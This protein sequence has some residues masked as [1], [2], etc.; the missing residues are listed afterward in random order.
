MTDK[1]KN[2]NKLI[3]IADSSDHKQEHDTLL[4][5][6]LVLVTHER[7]HWGTVC[8]LPFKGRNIPF[9]ASELSPQKV[10]SQEPA[11][12]VDHSVIPG[13]TVL[14]SLGSSLPQAQLQSEGT[15]TAKSELDLED[16]Y[17]I[18]SFDNDMILTN[19]YYGYEQGQKDNIVKGRL[20]N[21]I[22]FW[23]TVLKASSFVI[24]P[25]DKGYK[26][27]FF[28]KLLVSFSPNNRSALAD[29]DFVNEAVSSLLCRGLIQ[30]VRK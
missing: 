21:N 15:G 8:L 9:E 6:P 11:S 10:R 7:P 3:R 19:D 20:K 14:T 17:K 18:A 23:K 12:P 28:L 26:I 5:L 2:R 22:H 29:P 16:K 25:I 24:D 4:T 1:L 27:P 30:S 13:R